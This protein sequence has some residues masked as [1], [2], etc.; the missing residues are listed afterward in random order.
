MGIYKGDSIKLCLVDKQ[1]LCSGAFSL[2][3]TVT[4]PS[5][6]W[7]AEQFQGYY[8]SNQK[9]KVKEKKSLKCTI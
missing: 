7:G 4:D 3:A 6:V 2:Q 8:K 5:N 1:C 9:S